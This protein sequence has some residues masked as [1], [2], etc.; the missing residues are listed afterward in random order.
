MALKKK[1]VSEVVEE[2]QEPEVI[3]EVVEEDG[4]CDP[5]NFVYE[6]KAGKLFKGLSSDDVLC[7]INGLLGKV[8]TIVIKRK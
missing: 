3:E 5:Q 1:A 4:Y 2:I 7:V 8:E 6:L